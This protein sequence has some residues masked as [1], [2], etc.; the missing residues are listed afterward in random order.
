MLSND[1]YLKDKRILTLIIVAIAFLILDIV[2]GI[3][4]GIEF[5]GGTQIPVMLE[6]SV[7]ITTMTQLITTL[8]QRLSTF[9]LQQVTIEGIGNSEIYVVIPKASNAEIN[10]TISIINSQGKFD[11]IVD[12]RE[13]INGSDILSGSIGALQPQV[14]NNTVI[15]Q[16]DFYIT[17]SAEKPFAQ[18]VF[19]QGN[20]PIYMFLDRPTSSVV[21]INSTLLSSKNSS[22]LLNPTSKLKAMQNALQ[23][24]NNTIP[25]L[26]VSNTQSSIKNAET[27]L[28][29]NKNKYHKVI[30]SDNLNSTLVSYIKSL[31]YT[32]V[33]ENN[34]NM[35]PTF[36]SNG[37][38]STIVDSWPAVGL[39]SSPILSPGLA[40]GNVSNSFQISGA[41]PINIT[42]IQGKINYAQNESKKIVSVLS[43]GALPVAVITE[44]PTI[45]PPT[46]G[47]HFLFISAI[48]GIIA[49]IFVSIFMVL[50]YKRLFLVAPILLTTIMEV[51]IIVSVIGLIGTI[52]LAA[53]AGIIA[54]IGTGVDAQII[55]TDEILNKGHELTAK[56]LLSNAFYIVWID[57]GLLVIAM[58]P[59]FFSTSLVSV[60][61]FSESTIFGALLSVFITRPAYG[62]I[63]SKHYLKKI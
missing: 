49:I 8:N 29:N 25:I 61:G 30:M 17:N 43:G 55:I 58:L 57:A 38:N 13:A 37:F 63:V 2:Y 34:A 54:V 22:I 44:S 3:H 32:I 45:I 15:W 1:S 48:A 60:I 40:N 21:L 50:R 10:Q 62:A 39:I 35:T 20:K 23:F 5:V 14:L 56:T 16:V 51:F 52:D 18:A 24:G 47:S 36:I 11:G 46:L 12:G 31:N 4:F 33:L 53:V 9:G 28:L 7:N 19:G 59:L 27:F 41:A 26:T 42:S 6:H